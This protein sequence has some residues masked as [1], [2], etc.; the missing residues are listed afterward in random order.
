MLKVSRKLNKLF[1]HSNTLKFQY[2]KQKKNLVFQITIDSSS[3]KGSLF[4]ML[5]TCI[6]KA[7]CNWQ[8]NRKG[9][10]IIVL[11]YVHYCLV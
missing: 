6:S 5:L 9:N 2:Y 4:H 1:L 3:A 10:E 7:N 11:P 8:E